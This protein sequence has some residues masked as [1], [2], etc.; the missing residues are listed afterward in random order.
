VALF[1]VTPLRL[2]LP[3]AVEAPKNWTRQAT[4]PGDFNAVE[5]V[6]GD[7]RLVLG[8]D[9][10]M[11]LR[12][13]FGRPQDQGRTLPVTFRGGVHMLEPGAVVFHHHGLPRVE[14][15]ASLTI[16]LS[17]RMAKRE[18]ATETLTADLVEAFRAY[19]RPRMVWEDRRPIGAIFMGSGRGPDHNPRFW[20][21][22]RDLRIDTEE[23]RKIL[24]ERMMPHAD[25]CIKVLQGVDAQGM[26]LWD[27]EGGENPHPI[28]YIGDP[29]MVKILAPE[30]EDI[31]PDYFQRFRDAGL[32]VGCCLRPTQVYLTPPEAA[33]DGDLNSRWSV[34]VFPQWIEVDL[35]AD[36]TVAATEVIC[37]ADRAYQYT[38]EIRK[39][40]DEGYRKVA[41]RTGN[42]TPGSAESP[43][44]DTYDALTARFVKLTV[45]GVHGYDGKWISIREFRVRSPDGEN[46]ARGNYASTSRPLGRTAGGHGTGSH[47]PGRNPLGEDFSHSWPE[48]IPW[49]RFFPVVERMSRKIEYARERWGCTIFYVDTNGIHRPIG[50]EQTFKW[51][52]LDNHIWRDLHRRHPDVLLIPEFAPNPGQLAYTT[53]YLQPPYSPPILRESWRDLLPGAFGVSYTVNLNL[54]DWNEIRPRLLQGIRAGDVMFFR[55]WFGDRYNNM[56]K[57]LYDQAYEGGAVNPGLPASYLNRNP[58]R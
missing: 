39:D 3:Q 22:D 51:T 1:E 2:S 52:L 5:A 32:R 56:I 24:R 9:T 13:G 21:K 23:G 14:P 57:A 12:V 26:V 11:P 17:L 28:T 34:Q 7:T 20:F 36:R 27:P 49:W 45:T 25:R 4:L 50:E 41:D 10:V 54:D 6:F 38:M 33:C 48:G 53:T 29:R 15:G 43:L 40:G 37:H 19:H 42:Q 18:A 46:L 58:A 16:R 31:Y 8:C 47:H 55:G 30:M 44:R 35:G